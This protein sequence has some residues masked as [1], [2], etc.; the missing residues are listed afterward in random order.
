MSSLTPTQRRVLEAAQRGEVEGH[1]RNGAL[2]TANEV[3]DSGARRSV[4]I[5]ARWLMSAELLRPDLQPAGWSPSRD[6][7]WYFLWP[8]PAG[9]AELG[10][11]ETEED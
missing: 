1:I 5:S 10:I 9:R 11:T 8:P 6:S 3:L 7:A 4:T 2:R